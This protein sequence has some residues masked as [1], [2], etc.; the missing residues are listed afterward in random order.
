MLRQRQCSVRAL[1]AENNHDA[2]TR[3]L[4]AC[5]VSSVTPS[6]SPQSHPMSQSYSLSRFTNEEARA[7]RRLVS[8]VSER[9]SWLVAWSAET[10]TSSF[11][12]RLGHLA[13]VLHPA[14]SPPA[15][16]GVLS[17]RGVWEVVGCPCARAQTQRVT[18]M[19][20]Q[21]SMGENGTKVGPAWDTAG[22]S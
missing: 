6:L 21:V 17:I 9:Q 12:R 19:H 7:S 11:R 5:C 14:L 22:E 2:A 15:A 10:C 13:A 18:P 16:V 4:R 8:I 3:G 20:T 1:P